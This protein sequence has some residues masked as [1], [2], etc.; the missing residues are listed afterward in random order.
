M[1]KEIWGKRNMLEERRSW[2]RMMERETRTER[3]REAKEVCSD[4]DVIA[5]GAFIILSVDWGG[6]HRGTDS[7]EASVRVIDRAVGRC[8]PHCIAVN[9]VLS[10]PPER[11]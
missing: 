8:T 9:T 2:G 11:G 7:T 4:C 6:C 1:K 3:E 10:R 5:T